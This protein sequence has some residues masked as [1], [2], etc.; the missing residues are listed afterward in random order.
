MD[1]RLK[2]TLGGHGLQFDMDSSDIDFTSIQFYLHDI[3][4]YGL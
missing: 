1:F 4:G 2:W 3:I